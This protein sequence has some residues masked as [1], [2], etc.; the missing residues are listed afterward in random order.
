MRSSSFS[1]HRHWN[2][3]SNT[4]LTGLLLNLRLYVALWL[5]QQRSKDF[6]LS[7]IAMSVYSSNVCRRT[8]NFGAQRATLLENDL[9]LA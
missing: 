3:C 1:G 6:L 9:G 4:R 8:R 5:S 7:I 2:T